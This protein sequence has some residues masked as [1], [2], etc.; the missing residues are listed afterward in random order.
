MAEQGPNAG[1]RAERARERVITGLADLVPDWILPS[2][3]KQHLR[4]ARK[5]VL[6]AF[7]SMIDQAIEAQ[8]RG[9]RARR[10]P[11]KI[12]VE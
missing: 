5:E 2:E 10:A 3:G 9:G 6:L 8:E 4:N 7:R 11:S 12:E 1:A